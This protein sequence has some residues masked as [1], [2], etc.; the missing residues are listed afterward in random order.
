MCFFST[1]INVELD[2]YVSGDSCYARACTYIDLSG[3]M[4]IFPGDNVCIICRE[5]MTTSC[6]KLPCTHIFHTNCLRS[7]FQR[8][9]TCPTCR[10]DVLRQPMPRQTT[11]QQP[12]QQQQQPQAQ[13]PGKLEN[14][15]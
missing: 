11:P 12:A 9:Q 1:L 14:L 2:V 8:Q 6:K 7:W 15:Y 3:Y 13:Q 5:D 4:F 10:M